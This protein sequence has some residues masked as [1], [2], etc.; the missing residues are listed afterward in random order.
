MTTETCYDRFAPLSD[1]VDFV[2]IYQVP[3]KITKRYVII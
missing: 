3:L 2:F 1:A